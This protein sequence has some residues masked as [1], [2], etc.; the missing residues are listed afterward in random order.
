MYANLCLQ[1]LLECVVSKK[2][3]NPHFPSVEG[4]PNFT[5]FNFSFCFFFYSRITIFSTFQEKL[6]LV[7][8]DHRVWEI[9]FKI[10]CTVFEWG[11]GMTF[12][13]SYQEVEGSRNW[14]S[15]VLTCRCNKQH[16]IVTY[17]ILWLS[18]LALSLK[19]PKLGLTMTNYELQRTFKIKS[20]SLFFFGLFLNLSLK[21]TSQQVW[22]SFVRKWEKKSQYARLC[23][24]CFPETIPWDISAV[25]LF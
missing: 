13:S 17:S 14:D 1:G 25:I 4:V 3:K 22:L 10:T 7:R 16:F 20:Y 15:T 8:K 12:G 6:K 2:K 11:E 24:L 23:F 21:S 9:G 18:W 5:K 19:L